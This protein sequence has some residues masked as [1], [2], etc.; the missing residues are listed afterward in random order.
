MAEEIENVPNQNTATYKEIVLE[1]EAFAR[2]IKVKKWI[3][4]LSIL[5][6]I[7]IGFMVLM[8][9]VIILFGS[10]FFSEIPEAQNF[11]YFSILYLVVAVVYFIPSKYLYNFGKGITQLQSTHDSSNLTYS[12]VNISKMFTFMSIFTIIMFT[13]YPIII[14]IFILSM[15]NFPINYP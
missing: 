3:Y 11:Q 1:P 13:L 14:L 7:S 10:V 15:E 8:A 2:L 9:L 12:V 4:F 6:F 5:G